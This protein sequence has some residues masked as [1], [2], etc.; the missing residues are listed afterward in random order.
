MGRVTWRKMSFSLNST[1]V[2]RLVLGVQRP[3]SKALWAYNVDRPVIGAPRTYALLSAGVLRTVRTQHG[4][5]V[6]RKRHYLSSR[7]HQ[8]LNTVILRMF[9]ARPSPL[10]RHPRL[11]TP[12]SITLFIF[13]FASLDLHVAVSSSLW[14]LTRR[15]RGTPWPYPYLRR[16]VLRVRP[17]PPRNIFV[18]WK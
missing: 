16:G 1:N 11:F 7:E 2:F 15:H 9:M 14:P 6:R 13:F 8:I 4:Q 18:A 12:A 10:A 5:P 17:P 3:E